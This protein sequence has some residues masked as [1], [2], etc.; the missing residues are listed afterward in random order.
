MVHRTPMSLRCLVFCLHAASAHLKSARTSPGHASTIAFIFAK[1]V[2]D[3][4]VFSAFSHKVG[5]PKLN[6]GEN[7]IKSSAAHKVSPKSRLLCS[8]ILAQN[9]AVHL[10]KTLWGDSPFR[11]H[12]FG[13]DGKLNALLLDLDE[14]ESPTTNTIAKATYIDFHSSFGRRATQP[15]KRGDINE[16]SLGR[17]RWPFRLLAEIH[18]SIVACKLFS[19]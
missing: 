18:Y 10:L 19:L 5:E 3:H 12:L 6:F 11:V 17:G 2:D 8:S 1:L 9:R 16:Q 13:G 7:K 4:L 14:R 15:A